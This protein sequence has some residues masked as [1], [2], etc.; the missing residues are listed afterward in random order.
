MFAKQHRSWTLVTLHSKMLTEM[1]SEEI[2]NTKCFKEFGTKCEILY[3]STVYWV[4]L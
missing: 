3:N 2:G 1:L 4:S